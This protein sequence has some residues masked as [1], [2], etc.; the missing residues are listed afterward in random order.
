[1]KRLLYIVLVMLAVVVGGMFYLL[2]NLDGLVKRAIEVSGTNAL[3]TDVRVSSVSVDLANG[4]A[5][6]SG[7]SVANPPGFSDEDMVRF[8]ELYLA[9]DLTSLNTDIIRINS[10]RT[11]NPY[12]LYEMQGTRSNLDVVRERFPAQPA[13]TQ[14]TGGAAQPV[15]AINEVNITGIQG[16]LQSDLLPNPV[17]VNLGDISIPPV[18][19]TPEQLAQQIARPLLTQLGVRA[20]TALATTMSG[21]SVDELRTE[22]EGAIRNAADQLLNRLMPQPSTAPQD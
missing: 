6:L 14:S 13:P 15:I 19:G 22:A 18:Q 2:N 9:F 1:M 3:G 4:S 11:V 7:F 17:S 8:D 10:I 5:T 21:M 12:V 16:T 20:A